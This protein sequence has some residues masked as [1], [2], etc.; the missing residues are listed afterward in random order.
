MIKA[1]ILCEFHSH[2]EY[3]YAALLEADPEVTTYVP[4]PFLLRVGAKRYTPDFYVLRH[5]K[6]P[7]VIELKADLEQMSPEKTAALKAYFTYEL[8]ADFELVANE[9]VY[10]QE[11]LAQNWLRICRRLY[12]G[13]LLETN[14]LEEEIMLTALSRPGSTLWELIKPHNPVGCFE[15]EVALWRRAHKG[16]LKLELT[17]QSLN[18]EM[19]VAL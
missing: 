10:A 9:V 1:P 16:D 17:Q 8:R 6:A 4:Q 14:A 3:L 7:Q 2:A 19:E 5:K 11:I 13:R 12:L 18:Y 15:S